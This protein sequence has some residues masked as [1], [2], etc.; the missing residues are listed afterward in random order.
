MI[1]RIPQ[2]DHSASDAGSDWRDVALGDCIEMSDA[3]YS[4]KEDWPFINY[5]DTG[6]LTRG[7][8]LEF[9]SLTE[10]LVAKRHV[11]SEESETLSTLRDTLLPQLISG[12]IRIQDAE[13]LVEA[14]A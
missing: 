14:A 10:P 8:R 13:K 1:V 12:R 2:R 6:S 9:S 7:R 11:V 4:P 5:L 3:T